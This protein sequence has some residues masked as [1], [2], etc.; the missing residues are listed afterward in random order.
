M[1]FISPW[2]KI[3]AI[4]SCR[5][6]NY[7]IENEWTQKNIL[8][9][10]KY[11]CC[12]F[13]YQE[14]FPHP[15]YIKFPQGEFTPKTNRENVEFI[16]CLWSFNSL[17]WLMFKEKTIKKNFA[18]TKKIKNKKN[19]NPEHQF[20]FKWK[21]PLKNDRQIAFNSLLF[22]TFDH[23]NHALTLRTLELC[24]PPRSL[25]WNEAEIYGMSTYGIK[26][27]LR[28]VIALDKRSWYMLL[29]HDDTWSMRLI[30]YLWTRNLFEVKWRDQVDDVVYLFPLSRG[31]PHLICCFIPCQEDEKQGRT[32]SF[33]VSFGQ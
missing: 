32:I 17:C 12:H 28:P 7:D 9:L 21:F 2:R 16:A 6:V 22:M 11:S 30:C 5:Y 20:I 24:A 25:E 3:L 15:N 10:K 4:F 1:K 23:L 14:N 18:Y 27:K 8:V 31:I 13:C 33:R 26:L 19:K 29:S